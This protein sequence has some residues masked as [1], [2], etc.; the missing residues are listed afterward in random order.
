[1]RAG[2]NGGTLCV[3]LEGCRASQLR[4]ADTI[5]D[6]ALCF[7]AKFQTGRQVLRFRGRRGEGMGYMKSTIALCRGPRRRYPGSRIPVLDR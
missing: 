2:K 3:E 4:S 7:R 1:M 5:D 6:R